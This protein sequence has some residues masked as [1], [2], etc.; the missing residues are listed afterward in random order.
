MVD[1]LQLLVGEARPLR[2]NAEEEGND[3][4]DVDVNCDAASSGGRVGGAWCRRDIDSTCL[5][6]TI[7]GL[8]ST[9]HTTRKRDKCRDCEGKGPEMS[10]QNPNLMAG[11]VDWPESRTVEVPAE[12]I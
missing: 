8:V 5:R 10:K 2:I 12:I 4:A 1:M 9:L 6:T 7:S 3:V 11:F